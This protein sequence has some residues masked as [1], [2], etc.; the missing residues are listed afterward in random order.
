MTILPLPFWFRYLLFFLVW[1]LWLGLPILCWVEVVRMGVLVLSQNLVGRHSAF[2]LWVL[3]WLWV[4]HKWLLFCWDMFPLYPVWQEF[5]IMNGCWVLSYAFSAIY[6][7]D[8]VVGVFCWCGVSHWL[9]CVCWTI[10]VT[11]EWFQLDHGVWSFLW[12]VG[13][14]LLIFC[15]GLL[16]LYSS[17]ILACN[18]LYL[19]SVFLVSGWWWLH[20]MTLGVFP[21]LQ[22]FGRV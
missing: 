12:I 8:H 13:F 4:C 7:D 2:H 18:F 14:S 5:F 22:S 21:P 16:H 11:L 10:F 19:V 6:W 9:I 17:K 1:L 3:C 20:R 15:W